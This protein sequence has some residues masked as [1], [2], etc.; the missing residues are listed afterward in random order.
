VNPPSDVQRV[1]KFRFVG[2][3]LCLDF[4]NTVGGKRGARGREYLRDFNDFITWCEQAGLA[5]GPQVEAWRQEAALQP[6]RAQSVL[7]RAV[8]LRE[9]LH[10]IFIALVES[11]TPAMADLDLLNSELAQTLGRLRVTPQAGGFA[12]QWASEG[13]VLDQPLGPI[14]RSAAELL[15]S[16]ERLARVRCCEGG[17]CGWLFV[18]AS[19][20]HSRRWCDMRDCGNR[21]KARR[22]RQK[23]HGSETPGGSVPEQT[24]P[25]KPAAVDG[26]ARADEWATWSTT[27][28][29]A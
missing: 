21:S 27:R 2:G 29:G 28:P 4:C 18:D 20:N 24:A 3:E 19:K 9:A 8:I 10:R 17:N 22:H 25:E 12:W 13:V 26:G 1:T 15:V 11:E 7:T 5:G 23:R 6:E 16:S 14:C